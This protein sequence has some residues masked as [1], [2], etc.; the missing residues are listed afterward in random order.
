MKRL[1]QTSFGKCWFPLKTPEALA[2][3]R[4]RDDINLHSKAHLTEDE[5]LHA[6]CE[7]YI[8]RSH[9]GQQLRQCTRGTDPASFRLDPC[10]W[11]V[12]VS[13][14]D[15]AVLGVAQ[16]T[17]TFS[18]RAVRSA[19]RH[20]KRMAHEAKV[21]KTGGAIEPM[22][23]LVVIGQGYMQFHVPLSLKCVCR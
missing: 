7:C 15:T 19:L 4:N 5:L 20:A 11:M 8:I 10:Q 13:R 16:R 17:D 9:V 21:K 2:E 1:G 14:R 3:L 18:N 23:V 12:R 22:V 6:G